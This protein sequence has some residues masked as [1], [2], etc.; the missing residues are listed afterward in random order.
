MAKER[1]QKEE[2]KAI[3]ERKKLESDLQTFQKYRIRGD[4]RAR[5]EAEL[6]ALD[7]AEALAKNKRKNKEVDACKKL[8]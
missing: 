3:E 7:E 6:K 5:I 4:I 8:L 1:R 2:A